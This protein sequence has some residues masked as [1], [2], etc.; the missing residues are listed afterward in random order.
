MMLTIGAPKDD[1]EERANAKREE[2]P[3]KEEGSGG[4]T[5]AASLVFGGLLAFNK[6][7][8][9]DSAN[10]RSAYRPPL[11]ETPRNLGCQF[12]SLQDSWS[13]R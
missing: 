1:G 8:P 13:I 12:L 11:S 10:P 7:Q 5:Y 3:D 9:A 2:C 4:L 6:R